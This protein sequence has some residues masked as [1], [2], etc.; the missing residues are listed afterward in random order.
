MCPI[1][2]LQTK[3]VVDIK[4]YPLKEF[5]EAGLSVTVNTD[6]RTVSNSTMEKELEFVAN[7]FALG[8]DVIKKLMINAAN[9]A[10]ADDNIKHN[11]LNKISV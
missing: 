9:L 3:A 4:A 1:I 8:E 2:K 7:E 11:L 10:F 5:L 6:N